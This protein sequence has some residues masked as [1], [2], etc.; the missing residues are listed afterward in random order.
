LPKGLKSMSGHKGEQMK[1]RLKE[2][3]GDSKK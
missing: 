3:A 1:G 2:V